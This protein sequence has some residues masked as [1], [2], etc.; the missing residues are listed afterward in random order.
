[1]NFAEAYRKGQEG[2]LSLCYVKHYSHGRRVYRDEDPYRPYHG[3]P[4]TLRN[5]LLMFIAKWSPEHLAFEG[6]RAPTEPEPK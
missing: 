6:G 2:F 3:M 4:D 1:M 5:R